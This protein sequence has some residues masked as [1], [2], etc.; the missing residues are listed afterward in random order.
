M[1]DMADWQ[2][3]NMLIPEEDTM[4]QTFTITLKLTQD[5]INALGVLLHYEFGSN[6]E[7]LTL[8]D[9]LVNAASE[10]GADL[11]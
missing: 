10:A 1:G 2:L 7:A 5:E 11:P 4:E 8:Y 3:D 6:D 9:Q